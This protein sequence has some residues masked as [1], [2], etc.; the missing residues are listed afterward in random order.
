MEIVGYYVVK[1]QYDG[2]GFDVW[3]KDQCKFGDQ[4]EQCQW[5]DCKGGYVNG[6]QY[7]FDW[8]GVSQFLDCVVDEQQCDQVV[9]QK[10]QEIV[11][12][13]FGL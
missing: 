13:V 12:F 4:V 6:L 7:L 9:V 3:F 5:L 8:C 2:S 11:Y 1:C 10:V